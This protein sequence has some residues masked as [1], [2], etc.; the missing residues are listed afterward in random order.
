MSNLFNWFKKESSAAYDPLTGLETEESCQAR[1]NIDLE[2][3]L[4]ED[5]YLAALQDSAGWKIL[6]KHLRERLAKLEEVLIHVTELEEV[7]RVQEQI[8]ARREI[9]NFIE[10]RIQEG[11]SLKEEQAQHDAG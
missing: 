8:L 11:N 3:R 5:S 9:L 10:Y 1:Q 2:Q 4:E 6:E 7:R